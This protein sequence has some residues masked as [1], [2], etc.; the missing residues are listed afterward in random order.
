[1]FLFYEYKL[2]RI[3]FFITITA[4]NMQQKNVH[5]D[6]VALRYAES[7][8]IRDAPPS[9]RWMIL[10]IVCI[11]V[12]L[13]MYNTGTFNYGGVCDVFLSLVSG[14]LTFQRVLFISSS[15]LLCGYLM[16]AIGVLSRS[17]Y[18]ITLIGQ[19]INGFACA[20]SIPMGQEAPHNW[21]PVNEQA[22]VLSVIWGSRAAAFLTAN[23]ISTRIIGVVPE[24]IFTNQSRLEVFNEENPILRNFKDTLMLI[25]LVFF[26]VFQLFA[27][28]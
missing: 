16:V 2:L 26:R 17:N 9:K 8:E 13:A 15:L 4:T 14:Q 24:E 22:T 12:F 5:D 23:L 10:G 27:T 11:V 25:F 1:M 7:M 3:Y 19:T 28:S 18:A 20:I 6:V 21:F